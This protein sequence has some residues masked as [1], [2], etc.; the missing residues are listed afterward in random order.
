VAI[1]PEGRDVI[2]GF[3][4]PSRW[5]AERAPN[6]VRQDDGSDR[7]TEKKLALGYAITGHKSQGSEWPYVLVMLDPGADR[8]ASREWIYTAISRASRACF[9]IGTED[10]LRRQI[11]RTELPQRKTLLRELILQEMRDGTA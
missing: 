11:K 1:S 4:A 9:L 6:L 8:V 7:A 2:L 3:D 10:T 5:I